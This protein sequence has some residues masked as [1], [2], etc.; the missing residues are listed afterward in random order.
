MNVCKV[1]DNNKGVSLE[2]LNWACRDLLLLDNVVDLIRWKMCG[3]WKIDWLKRSNWQSYC[4]SNGRHYD[5]SNFCQFPSQWKKF[6]TTN[7]S[8]DI[9]SLEISSLGKII[10]KDWQDNRRYL[11]HIESNLTFEEEGRKRTYTQKPF[12]YDC[13][14]AQAL[15][16][17]SK[18]RPNVTYC[19]S[20]RN[21]VFILVSFHLSIL[22]RCF[23]VSQLS[24]FDCFVFVLFFFV[25]RVGK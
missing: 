13:S 1:Y 7:V 19:R 25:K 8:R 4:S 18:W 20:T 24:S 2:K 11:L 10:S 15:S 12:R 6:N 14:T 5:H 16:C 23:G 9:Y 21:N 3:K 17:N 22:S